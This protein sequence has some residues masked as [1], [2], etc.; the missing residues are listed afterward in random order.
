MDTLLPASSSSPLRCRSRSCFRNG[1]GALREVS[2]VAA[3]QFASDW[4][5]I[6]TGG[7]SLRLLLTR[8]AAEVEAL[9]RRPTPAS[10]RPS[11]LWLHGCGHRRE[12]AQRRFG[13]RPLSAVARRSV[14]P[15]SARSS[16]ASKTRSSSPTSGWWN[17]CRPAAGRRTSCCDQMARNSALVCDSSSMSSAGPG[18]CGSRPASE[19]R[20]RAVSC[21]TAGQSSK[22]LAGAVVEEHVPDVVRRAGPAVE[23]LRV[24][25]AAQRIGR[26]VV[27]APV[28]HERHAAGERVEGPLH[29]RADRAAGRRQACRR[30]RPGEVEEVQ[31]FGIV[32][33]QCARDGVEHAV[34]RSVDVA[35]LKLGVVVRAHA[36]EIRHLLATQPRHPSDVAVEHVQPGLLGR[37]PR[38]ARHQE[39]PDLAP[40]IH[41]PEPSS[42]RRRACAAAALRGAQQHPLP[43][44]GRIYRQGHD[45]DLA[46]HRRRSRHGRRVRPRGPGRRS[47]R[48]GHRPQPRHRALGR[49]RAREPARRPP[50]T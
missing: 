42:G 49:R 16:A 26:E 7:W 41:A 25:R 28:A 8:C 13:R 46:Y 21:A 18:S 37:H 17:R 50:S 5:H 40:A 45:E 19:R 35:A 23:D 2:A 30:L 43:G 15:G 22:K 31:P 27:P 12:P 36:G 9:G 29:A 48:R 14:R 6:G 34:G 33:A 1:L 47:Q 24:H 32:E 38:P 39:L 20:M 3:G 44:R 4:N 11:A 10:Q